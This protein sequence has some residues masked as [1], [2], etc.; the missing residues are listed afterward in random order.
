L[1]FRRLDMPPARDVVLFLSCVITC[2]VPA[3][4]RGQGGRQA[5]TRRDRPEVLSVRFVG[6]KHVDK[7]ALASSIATQASHCKSIFLEP[8]CLVTKSHFFYEHDY[9]DRDE[10]RR[11][12]LRVL[13]FYYKH[14]YRDASVDTSLAPRYGPVAR[15]TFTITEGP[16]TRISRIDITP[17]T[18]FKGKARSRILSLSPGDPLDLFV[19]DSMTQAMRTALWKEAYADVHIDTA[20]TLSAGPPPTAALAFTIKLGKKA[21]IGTVDVTGNQK[22]SSET[23]RRSLTFEPG[24]PFIR[25]DVNSNQRTLYQSGLFRS[26]SI[27]VT[28]DSTRGDSVKDITISV[29]EA[30]LHSAQL[31]AGFST[32]EFLQATGSMTFYNWLGGGRKLSLTAGVANI[33]APQLNGRAIF[34]DVVKEAADQGFS[35]S[36]FLQPEW[37]VSADLTQ[38]WFLSPDNS[39]GAGVF[40]RRRSAPGVY[41]DQSYGA[42]LTFTR[43][44]FGSQLPVSLRYQFALTNVSA[45][46]VYYC[47]NF[48]SCDIPTINA[49]SG[50]HRL[51]PLTLSATVDHSGGSFY[52]T[53][54]YTAHVELEHA[55]NVTASQFH[56]DRAVIDGTWYKSIAQLNRGAIGTAVL[57]LHARAGWVR[58]LSTH[59]FPDTTISDVLYP[60]VRFYAGGANSVRGFGENELGP[61]VLTISP[62]SLRQRTVQITPHHDTTIVFCPPTTPIQQCNPNAQQSFK[63]SKG[64]MQGVPISDAQFT[65]RP[66]GGNQLL[67]GSA[68]FRFPIKGN[69]GAAAF[70]D[71]AIVGTGSGFG[72]EPIHAAAAATPGLGIRYYSSV[73]AIRIDIGFNPITTYNLVVITQSGSGKNATLVKLNDSR[74]YAP[75]LTQGGL[76]GILN[77]VNL[78]LSIGQ[79]F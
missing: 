6:V 55:S 32:V 21:T 3:L 78:N 77:R 41:V 59:G 28:P 15:V 65:P 68:E 20:T 16:A 29:A 8:F 22:I 53:D 52:P 37:Q 19:L 50:Q 57:A 24:K 30:P 49:L 47:V 39:L 79:A 14:G 67:E 1:R 11:D 58:P 64:R 35:T 10:L 31:R 69:L 17:D 60:S 63:N 7:G 70:L 40:A 62:D 13:I 71:A 48:G 61:R 51:S 43:A 44:F 42:N 76:S 46:Q 36:P 45:A 4:L 25:S 38:P 75:A 72:G 27:A 73:G 18:L 54:G 56:Y 5:T 26:G 34:Q 33:L 9:L 74:V 23:V 2:L 12:V 66:L